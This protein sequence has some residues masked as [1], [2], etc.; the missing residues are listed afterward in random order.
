MSIIEINVSTGIQTIRD[1]TAEEIAALPPAPPPQPNG[2]GFSQAIK[3]AFG[4]IKQSN[5]LARK[6]PLLHPALNEQNWPDVQDLIIDA[7]QSNTITQAQYDAI[8]AI[9]ATY[10]IP[11]TL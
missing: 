3:S 1:M 5:I 7:L 9:A 6:Y 10:N 2:R 11:V 8:K 4:G